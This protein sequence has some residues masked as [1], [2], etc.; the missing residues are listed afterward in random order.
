MSIEVLRYAAFTDDGPRREP[1]RCRPGHLLDRCADARRRPGHRLLRDGLPHPSG[2]AIGAPGTSAPAPRWTSAATPPSRLPWPWP[3]ATAPGRCPWPPTPGRSRSAQPWT[4]RGLSRRPSPPPRP[5]PWP[6]R[7]STLR[8]ALDHCALLPWTWT[9]VSASRVVRREP[10]PGARRD[11]Q[12]HPRH[13]RLRL[14]GARPA[15]GRGGHGPPSTCS[16]G[17]TRRSSTRATCFRP[18]ASW[19]TRRR[20]PQR[21]R[22]AAT[23]AISALV[24]VPG[25]ARRSCRAC[26]GFTQPPLVDIDD[27]PAR[28]RSPALPPG[29]S[30]LALRRLGAAVDEPSDHSGLAPDLPG[31]QRREACCPAVP[32]RSPAHRRRGGGS[33]VDGC[34]GVRPPAHLRA[35][36]DGRA[37]PSGVRRTRPR[38]PDRDGRRVVR[39]HRAP[40]RRRP[41]LRSVAALA[42]GVTESRSGP[43]GGGLGGLPRRGGRL[44]EYWIQLDRYAAALREQTLA[45]PGIDL[46]ACALN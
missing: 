23:C 20:E 35:R 15:D 5:A 10:P 31:C 24:P 39:D 27:V 44:A 28:W 42:T 41:R 8:R 33:T 40:Q 4:P 30:C 34:S 3:S 2:R 6:S 21:P 11:R 36:R 14:R 29:S 1:R 17:A 18:A 38:P 43:A 46:C 22:S 32:R 7:T 19:R 26:H 9:R 12:A 37:H 16:A 13:P 45:E 25:R